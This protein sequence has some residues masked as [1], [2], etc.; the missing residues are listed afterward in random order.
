MK[1]EKEIKILVQ[2]GYAIV[3]ERQLIGI[4]EHTHREREGGE[5]RFRCERRE[6]KWK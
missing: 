6:L 3:I 5:I 2:S 4:I 1:F